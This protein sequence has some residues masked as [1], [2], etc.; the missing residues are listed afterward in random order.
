MNKLVLSLIGLLVMSSIYGQ[1]YAEKTKNESISGQWLF[2]AT[3]NIANPN[4]H[5]QL[6]IGKGVIGKTV[7]IHFWNGEL[8]AAY[9][10][11]SQTEN[12]FRL[13][14]RTDG[15]ILSIG[16]GTNGLT[17]RGD[18]I[19][20]SGNDGH[21]SGLNADKIDGIEG[22]D[23]AKL[24]VDH[25]IRANWSF[26]NRV[27][28]KQGLTANSYIEVDSYGFNGRFANNYL[29]FTSRADH[30]YANIEQ[31]GIGSINFRFEGT[32]KH[33]IASNGIKI[34]AISSTDTPTEALEVNG[35]ASI[36]GTL[37]TNELKVVNIVG[38]NL[39]LS[40]NIAANKI[41]LNTNGNT[42]D[43]VFE[44]DYN[45]R[46]L[47]EVNAFI[48]QNKH[49]PDVPSASEMEEE[50]VNIAEMNK[51]LLQKVEELT[52]YII[53]KDNEITQLKQHLKNIENNEHNKQNQLEQRLAKIEALLNSSKNHTK[54]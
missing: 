2:T 1:E 39:N 14:N 32:D 16:T 49:L 42:A 52:L 21:L 46:S 15:S 4:W 13:V 19:W 50:G 40:G 17:W 20:H 8:P 54:F 35:N 22:S 23:L 43:F 9:I 25:S 36:F 6:Y 33:I 44:E 10:G 51:I 34:G 12:D 5:D 53:D 7:N 18:T 30:P 41:T 28:A 24:N 11:Y 37:L 29:W 3:P 38:S 45:L 27:I 31:K 48:E 26:D 47:N